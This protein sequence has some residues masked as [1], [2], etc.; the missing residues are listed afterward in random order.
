MSI[1]GQCIFSKTKSQESILWT[2]GLLVSMCEQEDYFISL[3]EH[4]KKRIYKDQCALHVVATF[5]KWYAFN[6]YKH[7]V[8]QIMLMFLI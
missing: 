2:I 7:C 4:G 5:M 8:I 6:A 1:Q 3:C